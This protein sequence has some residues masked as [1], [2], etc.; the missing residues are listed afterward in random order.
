MWTQSNEIQTCPIITLVQV[1]NGT[2]GLGFIVYLTCFTSLRTEL[3]RVNVFLIIF[4]M[5]TV[6][7]SLQQDKD[8]FLGAGIPHGE[9]AV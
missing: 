2:P 5:A 3:D 8:A 6:L 9:A 4:L 7:P 1:W